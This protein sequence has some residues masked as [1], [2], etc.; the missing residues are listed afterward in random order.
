M[1]LSGELGLTSFLKSAFNCWPQVD[2]WGQ[3]FFGDTYF[4]LIV[5]CKTKPSLAPVGPGLNK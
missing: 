4:T 3:H 5:G 2:I 1:T